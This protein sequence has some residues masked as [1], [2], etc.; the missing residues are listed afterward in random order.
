MHG[1]QIR[2]ARILDAYGTAGFQVRSVNVYDLGATALPRGSD[3]VDYPGISP[4]RSWR[5]R[6]IPLIEDLTSGSFIAGDESA[7]RKISSKL[8][9]SPVVIHLEQPWLFPLVQ[10]WRREGVLG[11]HRLI[12]GSQNVESPLKKAILDQ[13][14][15][16]EAN[17]VAEDIEK[18]ETDACQGADVALAV[19]ESDR[20]ALSHLSATP[21]ILAEN[22]IAAWQT[23]ESSL[24][25]WRN[26]L[27]ENP[28]AVFVASAHPPNISGFFDVL[29]DSLGFMAPDQRICVV[30]SVGTHLRQHPSFI[31]WRELNE[32]RSQILGMIDDR[33]L[34]AVRTL[35]HVFILPISEGGGSNLKTAEALYSGKHV[36]GTETSFRGYDR[37]MGMPGVH[38]AKA[39]DEFRS[40]LSALLETPPPVLPSDS[41]W[42]EVKKSLLWTST[43]RPMVDAAL[44]LTKTM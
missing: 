8:P 26:K 7:Y 1:G 9:A 24:G 16:A 33:D 41:P 18:L 3:D 28:F 44:E 2:L 14:H 36:L 21:V 12:Y 23:D 39:G 17:E 4:F 20:Q 32:S 25:V 22:G 38:V 15:V 34:A 37:F 43:L 6:S 42:N 13:Y 10:R 31:R 40:R 29:G 27:P 35:A 11:E 5:G 30:G 19:S